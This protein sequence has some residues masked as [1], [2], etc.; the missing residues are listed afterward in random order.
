[1]NWRIVIKQRAN[2]PRRS[3]R[4]CCRHILQRDDK[5]WPT[6]LSW[7]TFHRLIPTPQIR[8]TILV[9]YKFVCMYVCNVE[10]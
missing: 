9:L 7:P 1:M 2:N 6:M 8:S 3:L 10:T 5:S 4:V